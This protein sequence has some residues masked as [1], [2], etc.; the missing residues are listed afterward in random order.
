MLRSFFTELNK[1]PEDVNA[2]FEN[3]L[4][5]Y[6][7]VGGMPEVVNAFVKNKDFGEVQSIQEKIL[8]AYDDIAL[9]AKGAEKVKV[10]ACYD[11]SPKQLARES[12]KFN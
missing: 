3:I 9:H 2:K 6:I 10:R 7:V 11:R 8:A 5:E 12:K 1:V 4:R